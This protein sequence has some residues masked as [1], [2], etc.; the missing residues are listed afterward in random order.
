MSAGVSWSDVSSSPRAP[1][2]R[3]RCAPL[4]RRQGRPQHRRVAPP[5][6]VRRASWSRLS[7]AT[8][9]RALQVLVGVVICIG[10]TPNSLVSSVSREGLRCSSPAR[11]P[12][13][14]PHLAVVSGER[15]L[16]GLLV[17]HWS[18]TFRSVGS[19]HSALR[20]P[21]GASSTRMLVISVF[22]TGCVLPSGRF[23]VEAADHVDVV[24]RLDVADQPCAESSGTDIAR[25]VAVELGSDLP[26]LRRLKSDSVSC[27]PVNSSS[28]ATLPFSEFGSVMAPFS[29]RLAGIFGRCTSACY[30]RRHHS[31]PWG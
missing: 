18:T 30:R 13:R 11:R 2:P 23:D 21:S 14:E 10:C 9:D 22:W 26:R 15:D 17:G 8:S 12:Q 16:D 25:P 5:P 27:L 24:A 20:E 29:T 19:A 3:R 7:S 28:T 6:P 1:R 4:L 31:C